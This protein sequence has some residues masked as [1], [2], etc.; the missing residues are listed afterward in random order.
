MKLPFLSRHL[1]SGVGGNGLEEFV[2]HVIPLSL[3]RPPSPRKKK[4]KERKE[5]RKFCFSHL[6]NHRCTGQHRTGL[7]WIS[8]RSIWQSYC[9]IANSSQAARSIFL[10][11]GGRDPED[12]VV[13]VVVVV[14][15]GGVGGGSFRRLPW[16]NWI[17]CGSS[18]ASKT[19]QG[20]AIIIFPRA[21]PLYY[22]SFPISPFNCCFFSGLFTFACLTV[23]FSFPSFLLFFR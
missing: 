21:F 11:A 17:S 6:R 10:A 9:V 4:G 16:L 8:G 15:G 7:S 23:F 3:I 18:E 13:P 19:R 2:N 1:E 20:G 12:W 5:E 22:L 14:V